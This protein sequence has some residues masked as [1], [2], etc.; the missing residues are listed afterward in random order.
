MFKYMTFMYQQHMKDLLALF[1]P[2]MNSR[3]TVS[4]RQIVNANSSVC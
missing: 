4:L 3:E 2:Q 1:L